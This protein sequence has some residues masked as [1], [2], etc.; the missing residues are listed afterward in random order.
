[1][2]PA[3]W[4]VELP[5]RKAASIK[6]FGRK[7]LIK[8][9]NCTNVSTWIRIEHA[10]T[11]KFWKSWMQS[12]WNQVGVQSQSLLILFTQLRSSKWEK[13]RKSKL[14]RRDRDMCVSNLRENLITSRPRSQRQGASVHL[15]R[16]LSR[17]LFFG[18]SNIWILLK[19]YL[20]ERK[21]SLTWPLF[22]HLLHQVCP[23]NNSY[24]R[25]FFAFPFWWLLCDCWVHQLDSK[26]VLCC[27]FS[28]T[29]PSDKERRK[30]TEDCHKQEQ[31]ET[32]H[33]QPHV[34]ALTLSRLRQTSFLISE[35]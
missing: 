11:S 17:P 23:L 26:V 30:E 22:T 27:Y 7:L 15:G 10:L 14:F 13:N 33:D 9:P 32:S 18:K 6:T 29:L 8:K 31:E 4:D 3:I 2:Y 34:M 19:F 24:P 35:V 25:F 28:T 21:A 5:K 12:P 16:W 20:F 1:M